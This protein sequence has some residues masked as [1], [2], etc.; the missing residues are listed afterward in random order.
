MPVIGCG[1]A[2]KGINVQEQNLALAC[3]RLSGVVDATQ[4]ERLRWDRTEGP[5][6]AK[7]VTFLHAALEDRPDFELVEEGSTST[8]K[9][10]IMKIHA[11]RIVALFVGLDKGRAIMGAAA[12]ERGKYQLSD[13]K[14]F[15]AEFSEVDEHWVQAVLQNLFA[16]IQG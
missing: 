6:L 1:Q 7:M 16:R 5:M 4:F 2:I 15:A 11:N 3:D 8:V 13:P 10:F 12:I 14:P 9:R